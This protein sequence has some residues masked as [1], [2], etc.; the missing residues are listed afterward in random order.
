MA[1]TAFPTA[2]ATP[3]T[4]PFASISFSAFSEFIEKQFS[5]KISLATVLTPLSTMAENTDLLNLHAQQQNPCQPGEMKQTITGWIKA[6]SCILEQELRDE[7][8]MLFQKSKG[9]PHLS[10]DAVTHSISKKLDAMSKILGLYP[11]NK[12][13]W[14]QGK[15]QAIT[16]VKCISVICPE[17]PEC[18]IDGCSPQSFLQASQDRDLP[19]VTLIKNSQI[20]DHAYVLSGQCPKCNTRYFADHHSLVSDAEQNNTRKL[21]SNSAKYLKVG[22][23]LW[24]DCIFAQAVLN[25]KYSFHASASAYA[26]FW[27]NSFWVTQDTSSRKVSCHQ[28]WHTFI[29]ESLHLVATA[30][31]M[32]LVLP[33]D[34]DINSVTHQALQKLGKSGL[35][36]RDIHTASLNAHIHTRAL[37]MLLLVMIQLLW[38]DRMRIE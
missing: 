35:L 36:L 30:S 20:H 24:V 29:Q 13:S 6:L 38:L 25:G 14:F 16:P 1:F 2:S 26:E 19:P 5:S 15:F 17:T 33:D 18:N 10:S 28:I 21:Y 11:Y 34:L 4:S 31:N 8:H 3:T 7:F 37:L 22:Q 27:N 23:S 12:F 9:R 32:S